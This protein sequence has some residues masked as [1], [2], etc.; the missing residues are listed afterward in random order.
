MHRLLRPFGLLVPALL[1]SPPLAA[2]TTFERPTSERPT[3]ERPSGPPATPLDAS[4]GWFY[5]NSDI[6]MDPAWVFGELPNGVRYAV[7]R[8]GVPPGQVSVRV[9]MDVGSLDER[10]SEGGWAHLMEHISFRGSKLVPDGESKRIW[11]RLGVTFG[12][13]VNA[14]TTPVSTTYKLDLPSAQPASVEETLKIMAGMMYVPSF[15]A[16]STAAET[17]VVEA[18]LREGQGPDTRVN[19]QLRE[20]FF[21]GQPFAQHDPIGSVETLRAATPATLK[22][23]HDRWY[24]PDR[25]AV[26][27]AGDIDPATVV[28]I[29][30]RQ[31]GSW[32][33]SAPAPAHPDLGAPDPAADRVA[34]AV[35]PS[36]PARVEM[37]VV[38]PW[39]WKADT[40]AYN[41]GLMRQQM[42][43][44]ILNRRLES[45]ARAGG[46]FLY[47]GVSRSDVERS[48]D[49]TSVSVVPA[50]GK[51]DVAVGDV[52]GA[53][54][55]AI[56]IAP[57][58]AE[59][60]REATEYEQALVTAVANE[61]AAP[62]ARL[63]D[64]LVSALD[65]AETSTTAAGA[66][67]IFR[68]ARDSFTPDRL[69]AET[70]ALFEGTPI[71]AL[72]SVPAADAGAQA[73]LL[74]T[75][76][77]PIAV[78][79][80]AG[81]KEAEAI[82]MD[83]LPALGTPAT[84]VGRA[85]LPGSSQEL[86]IEVVRL[87]NGVNL[88]LYPND[89]EAG[90]IY[91]EARFGT[92]LAGLAGKKAG[93][94]WSGEQALIDAGLAGLNLD[95]LDRLTTG[96]QV[97]MNFDV[98]DDHFTLSGTTRRDDLGDQLRLLATKLSHPSWDA[99]AVE[100][101]RNVL[102]ASYGSQDN[103][104]SAVV[105][106]DLAGFLH[107]GD[108]RWASPSR[109]DIQT[110]TADRLKTYWT[111]ILN[112]GSIEV[113]IFGDYD[114]A[115]AIR[116]AA[117]T[118]GALPPRPEV[119]V[120]VV[121]RA[122]P[123]F[124]PAT[125]PVTATHTGPADQAA[126]VLAWPTGA[127][128]AKLDDSY[129][130]EVLAAVFGDRLLD[131][132]RSEEGESYSPQVISQWPRDATAGGSVFVLGQV[133]PGSAERFFTLSEAIAADLRDHP[134]SADEFERARGPILQNYARASSG[135]GF[136]LR[137]LEGV[138]R[139]P[140]VAAVPDRLGAALGALTPARI[141]ALA[142]RYLTPGTS[143]RWVVTPATAVR[144]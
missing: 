135:N 89:G 58:Q 132:L 40:V 121:A 4:R 138:S 6:P 80:S 114:R 61:P 9:R 117:E 42:A 16:T 130:L 85:T 24:R 88:V 10:A 46:S 96:R 19:D 98:A 140:A 34:V 36:L 131:R 67:S 15:E 95:Q 44:Q 5:E 86:R 2:Q 60:D 110:L 120:P 91:V 82:S 113:A 26:V 133:R 31:F 105:N 106:R 8:N 13:D 52:R 92:G 51:W 39:R 108:P 144:G 62:G 93:F 134:M 141:Q 107:G 59:I 115:T 143:A 79:A 75:L 142:Q 18:E 53:I 69:L 100:R 27:I 12:S 81:R 68:S 136:W 127:G 17:K 28:P 45:Q 47:A 111:P 54:A 22:A 56:A 43:L 50:G 116:Q 104:A 21:A 123:M 70:A 38:R 49:V 103:S 109:A 73:Q 125:R 3:S 101:V 126:A 33:A 64:D 71:R 35:E 29:I 66:L 124:A 32:S 77:R 112:E 99:R 76:D 139:D 119:A 55:D 118:F 57:T 78:D 94:A 1:L 128:L 74:A 102:L 97:G 65:I 129:G 83:V 25:T 90:R 87:S 23:F 7:R 20:L 14:T 72:L 30:Q 84:V 37:A 48:G 11:Q 122:Q 41:Q 137:M 63:A